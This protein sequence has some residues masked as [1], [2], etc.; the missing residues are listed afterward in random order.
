MLH[1]SYNRLATFF[2]GFALLFFSLSFA[3]LCPFDRRS[4]GQR[5]RADS[6][7]NTTCFVSAPAPPPIRPL[8]WLCSSS[9]QPRPRRWTLRCVASGSAPNAAAFLPRLTGRG[10]GRHLG[11]NPHKIKDDDDD[12][13]CPVLQYD[14]ISVR[15]PTNPSYPSR[16]PGSSAAVLLYLY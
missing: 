15:G 9:S 13:V 14:F 3:S 8:W 2:D 5:T 6:R 7:R 1:H 11:N 16:P 4:G 12:D 10:K